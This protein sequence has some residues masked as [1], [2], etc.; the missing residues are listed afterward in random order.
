VRRGIRDSGERVRH[1]AVAGS[2]YPADPAT[3]AATVDDLLDSVDLPAGEALAAAYVVPHAGYR[4][5]GGTAAHVYARLRRHAGSVARVMLV[6]PAHRVPLKGCAV[7]TADRWLTP[8]GEVDVDP[9]ARGLAADGHAAPDD[10][11]HAPEHSLEVQVPFLQRALPGVP[12][13]PVTV[14]ASTADDVVVTVAAIAG[15]PGTVVVCSTDLSHYLPDAQARLQDGRTAAA[16]EEL[17]ADRIGVRDAC[18]VYALRGTVAW[19]RHSG[20][21]VRRLALTTSADSGGDP[22]RVVGYPAF[23]FGAAARL[24]AAGV[25]AAAE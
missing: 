25:P 10:A 6:G 7:S 4:Y 14:G 5:S 2:F 22:D 17:R 23:A 16:I 18:G 12:I 21:A 15:E 3:L 13:V 1:P 19:A 9:L 8:L 11:S 24:G 20:L